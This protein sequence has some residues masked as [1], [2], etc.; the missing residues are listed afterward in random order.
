MAKKTSYI[1]KATCKL[2][3][4]EAFTVYLSRYQTGGECLT[5]Q[6]NRAAQFPSHRMALASADD[7]QKTLDQKYGDRNAYTFEVEAV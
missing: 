5:V 6:A 2:S 4:V 3:E 1:V 7:W